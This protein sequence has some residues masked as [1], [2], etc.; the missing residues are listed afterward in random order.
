MGME[1]RAVVAFTPAAAILL[2]RR[3][4]CPMNEPTKEFTLTIHLVHGEAMRFKLKR[5]AAE[6][7]NIGTNLE[8]GLKAQYVGVELNGKLVIVPSHNVRLVE[9]DPAPGVLVAHV[10]RDAT[11]VG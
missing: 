2:L 8:S 6:V 1:K 9:V 7:R 10:I 3:G 4:G 11:P 5:T